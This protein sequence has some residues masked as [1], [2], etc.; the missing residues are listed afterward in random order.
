M[1]CHGHHREGGE[2]QVPEQVAG[3]GLPLLARAVEAWLSLSE[4]GTRFLSGGRGGFR[5]KLGSRMLF[6]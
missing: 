2:G 6:P 4:T 3:S 1:T 5:Q